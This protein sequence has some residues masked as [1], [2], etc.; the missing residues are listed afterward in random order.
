[1]EAAKVTNCKVSECAYN[2]NN[3]CHA[4]AI[5]IGDGRCPRCHT[6][7]RFIMNSK[8]GNT[9]VD[10][11]VGAC[12]ISS[13]IHNTGLACQAP[14]VLIDYKEQQPECLVFQSS[15]D[16]GTEICETAPGSIS[17]D[18]EYNAPEIFIG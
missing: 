3:I 5:T 11:S 9:G 8:A 7:C 15:Y 2:I 16:V 17:D 4:M 14:E 1:M 12:R 10:A 6:F 18:C 13:C